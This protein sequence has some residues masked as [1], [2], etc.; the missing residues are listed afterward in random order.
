MG[1]TPNSLFSFSGNSAVVSLVG[2]Y[3]SFPQ[4]NSLCPRYLSIEFRQEPNFLF[5]VFPFYIRS[6]HNES[7][8]RDSR[9]GRDG[10]D[11]F[12]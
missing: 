9:D 1:K 12:L 4:S 3:I 11:M 2:L 10:R 7:G 6:S 5:L 8:I